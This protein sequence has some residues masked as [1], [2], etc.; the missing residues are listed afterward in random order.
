M[1]YA[2]ETEWSNNEAIDHSV[3][4]PIEDDDVDE[5]LDAATGIAVAVVGGV[6]IW[7]VTLFVLTQI[8]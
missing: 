5:P 8:F 4:R 2:P 1:I 6:A 3:I 7:L